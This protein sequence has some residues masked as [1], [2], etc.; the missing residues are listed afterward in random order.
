MTYSVRNIVIAVALAVVAAILVI[1]Y[2]QGVA[3]QAKK[4]QQTVPVLVAKADITA[5][6]SVADALSAGSFETRQVVVQ[7]EVPGAFDSTTRLDKASATNAP[8]A[9]GT[10]ITAAM[11]GA[12]Q[13]N[14]VGTQIKG[15]Q[16]A[17]QIA[18][19][20]NAV[21]GG[22]LRAGDHVDLIAYGTIHPSNA[23][24]K[25]GD[26]SVAR[27]IMTNV[28]VIST[29]DSGAGSTPLTAS[30]QGASSSGSLN[31]QSGMGV[32]LN[33]PQTDLGNLFQALQAG[34]VWFVL[35]PQNGAQDNSSLSV[36]TPC[37]LFAAGLTRAQLSSELPVCKG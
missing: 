1:V 15:T 26:E 27:V 29:T 37:T 14:P 33:V 34:G 16:R 4:S 22:T 32:I 12:A 20:P 18:L 21:L 6:T 17:V 25:L 31:G 24:S 30:S 23:A 35:R 8:I 28:P 3:S 2:T 9:A 11:F 36:A 5:G 10:Q 13:N 19:N 7:D